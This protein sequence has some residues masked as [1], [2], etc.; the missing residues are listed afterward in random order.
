VISAE[1]PPLRFGERIL[2]AAPVREP[3]EDAELRVVPLTDPPGLDPDVRAEAKIDVEIEEIRRRR[4]AAR[5]FVSTRL[6][7]AGHTASITK[8]WPVSQQFHVRRFADNS[9][10]A[11]KRTTRPFT[12][13]LPDLLRDRE[14]SLRA[15]ARMVGVGDDHLSRVLRGARDKRATGEL[16]RRVAVALNLPEDYFPEARMELVVKRLTEEPALRDKLYDQLRRRR[17]VNRRRRK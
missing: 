8:C 2:V 11:K 4:L 10:M 7:S 12:E 15:V 1:L 5:S 6:A 14:I 17:S 16:T 3:Q 13:E 9:Y